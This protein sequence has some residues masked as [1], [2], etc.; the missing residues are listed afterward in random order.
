[1][2]F[3]HVPLPTQI[4]KIVPKFL[5]KTRVYDTPDG[6][7]PSITSILNKLPRFRFG[8][9]KWIEKVGK[10]VAKAESERCLQR[11]TKFHLT[12]QAY[13]ENKSNDEKIDVLP[14]ALFQNS[15]VK[16]NQ[17]NFIQAIEQPMWSKEFGIAGTVDCIA[18]Y[19]NTLSIIDFKTSTK[20]KQKSW[21]KS[22]FLQETS[23]SLM[24]EERTGIPIE[25]LVTIISCEDGTVQEFVETRDNFT[26]DLQSCLREYKE[27]SAKVIS[28]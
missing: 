2:S 27:I 12:V 21:I 24:Y 15:L 13:L 11:G 10:E 25:Q 20:R 8:L 6:N 3:I 18:N 7:F 1:M 19:K 23:Y 22:Y 5:N 17:I 26:N 28:N 16:L 4:P 9:N 14:K